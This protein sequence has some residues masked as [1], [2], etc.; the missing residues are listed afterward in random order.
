[1]L[2]SSLAIEYLKR[3]WKVLAIP[4]VTAVVFACVLM[5]G[6]SKY[7]KG[8]DAMN[9]VCVKERAKENAERQAAVID[10]QKQWAK[11]QSRPNADS[12]TL[13]K[14]MRDGQL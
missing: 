14:R 2:L 5:Y 4:V 13:L 8:Y 11:I 3:N 10:K 6:Q 12:A 9:V 7:N 1:M